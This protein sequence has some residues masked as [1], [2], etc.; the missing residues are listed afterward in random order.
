MAGQDS[1]I[2]AEMGGTKQ[3]NLI[4][5]PEVLVALVK[6]AK[7]LVIIIG[8]ESISENPKDAILLSAIH[9]LQENTTIPVISTGHISGILKEKGIIPT[10]TFGCMEIISRLCDP[11]WQGLDG[12]G[13]YDV[14]LIA[15]FSYTLAGLLLSGLKQG[16]KGM[17]IIS[18]DP[19]YHPHATWSY[20]N[21]KT[22]SWKIEIEKFI[23]LLLSDT[24]PVKMHV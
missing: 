5:K 20:P 6:K 16:A 11:I 8:T 7:R 12:K 24:K 14:V 21:M 22:E 23:D 18:I 17:K 3:A 4:S 10:A 13:Q 15:G 2:R 19:K 9:K 1:W